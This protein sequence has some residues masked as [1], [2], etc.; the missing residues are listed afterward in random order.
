MLFYDQQVKSH[1]GNNVNLF[2]HTFTLYCY[3]GYTKFVNNDAVICMECKQFRVYIHTIYMSIKELLQ[4][5]I[6]IP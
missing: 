3:G 2:M 4:Y 6:H 5:I 1:A